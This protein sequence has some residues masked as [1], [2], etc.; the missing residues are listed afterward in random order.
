LH[1]V[2]SFPAAILGVGF[3][4]ILKVLTDAIQFE[5]LTPDTLMFAIVGKSSSF[6]AVNGGMLPEPN[7][8]NPIE[9]SLLVQTYLIFV[10]VLE[11]VIESVDK[12][13]HTS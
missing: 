11:N 2:K 4:I 5:A 1:T 12:P 3:M 8:G 6:T 13:L 9:G 10:T 7:A